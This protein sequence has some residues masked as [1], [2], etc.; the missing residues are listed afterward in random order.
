MN[1]RRLFILPLLLLS[2]SGVAQLQK[3]NKILGGTLNYSTSTNTSDNSGVAG[4]STSKTNNLTV[5]PR[6]GFFVSDRTVVGLMFDINSYSNETTNLGGF[7]Y[8]YES[9]RFGFGPFVRRYFPVKDWV[10]FYGHA[11][12]NY[13][14]GEL[15]QTYS[16]SPSQ[17][18]ERSTNTFNLG[19]AL[20]LAFFPTNWMSVDLSMNPLSFSHSVNE[21][22]V[23]S[24]Y[25]DEN[26][27]SFNLNLSSQSF[28]IGA[29]F[30]LNKK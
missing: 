20:G 10:A 21:N 13:S 3:G 19:A 28:Y 22:E 1:K 24:S 9:S 23:G 5:N 15:K 8:N 16:N 29:H 18:Y 4:G 17:N 26:T 11:D 25:A 30:F 6:L 27:S 12:M 2:F 14:F 7:E